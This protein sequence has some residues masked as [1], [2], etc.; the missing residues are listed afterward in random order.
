[1]NEV[2]SYAHIHTFIHACNVCVHII[3]FKIKLVLG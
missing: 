3:K 1:M 2:I